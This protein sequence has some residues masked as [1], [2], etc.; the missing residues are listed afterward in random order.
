M[1]PPNP[2][3]PWSGTQ[4]SNLTAV[5][6]AITTALGTCGSVNDPWQQGVRHAL[7]EMQR[8]LEQVKVERNA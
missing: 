5:E 4:K 7:L 2:P 8:L 1:P 6:T 3:T